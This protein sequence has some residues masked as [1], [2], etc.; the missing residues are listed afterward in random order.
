MKD[1]REV[2]RI[3]AIAHDRMGEVLDAL[4]LR[5]VKPGATLVLNSPVR[6]DHDP[7][8]AIWTK[9][10]TIAFKDFGSGQQ[11]DLFGLIAYL[12]RWDHLPHRGFPES[13]R[14]L[15]DILGLRSMTAAQRTAAAHKGRERQAKAAAEAA[16]GAE[17]RRRAARHLFYHARP[18]LGT[19][20]ETY[21]ASR[22]IELRDAPFIGP[23]GGAL[24]PHALRFVP[25]LAHTDPRTKEETFWPALVAACV[26]YG[27]AYGP[28]GTIAAVH[29][30]WLM[31]D[32]RGKAEVD[33]PKMVL[34]TFG[35]CVIPLWRGASHLPVG[36]AVKHGLI[37]TL[38][39]VEGIE[40]GLTAAMCKPEYRTWAAISLSNLGHVP[41]LP[42]FDGVLMH[43]Q[44][45]WK[46]LQAVAAFDAARAAIERRVP[47]AEIRATVGKDLNDSLRG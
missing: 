9:G 17:W 46:N 44:N 8:L 43:R 15:Q 19:V 6:E 47:V 3:K 30:T 39:L 1:R 20:G 31:P 32:G 7:S 45:D 36:E 21:L 10:G 22:G 37:E 16:A 25:R 35:S 40:D 29:R 12:K 18:L 4:G 27:G 5:G 24:V 14:W 38:V 11:G 42:C 13:L 41:V 23:K 26:D 33:N 2:E 34:G 28:P